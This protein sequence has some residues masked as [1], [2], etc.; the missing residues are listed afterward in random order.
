MEQYLRYVFLVFIVALSALGL[1]W[2][3]RDDLATTEQAKKLASSVFHSLAD[4]AA[5]VAYDPAGRDGYVS[6]YQL[7][8]DV[9]RDEFSTSRRKKLWKRVEQLVEQNSNVRARLGALDSGDVGRGWKWIG[10]VRQLED[11]VS[12]SGSRRGSKRFSLPAAADSSPMA[13]ISANGSASGK[14][15]FTRWEDTSRPQF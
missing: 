2:K 8:D 6:V 14:E 1:W 3:V 7:R 13:E 10:A 15:I 12:R 9:M 4:H 11:S 5:D